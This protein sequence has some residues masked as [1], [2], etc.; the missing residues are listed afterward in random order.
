MNGIWEIIGKYWIN[1]HRSA[2]TASLGAGNGHGGHAV[3]GDSQIDLHV[4]HNMEGKRLL[5]LVRQ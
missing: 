2:G 5:K 1:R 4:G 3:W